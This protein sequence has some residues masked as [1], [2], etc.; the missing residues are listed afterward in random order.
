L[1]HFATAF[2]LACYRLNREH[3]KHKKELPIY[4]LVSEIEEVTMSRVFLR[5]RRKILGAVLADLGELPIFVAKRAD[6][7]SFQPPRN[8]AEMEGVAAGTPSHIAS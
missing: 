7:T 1:R 5:G 6:R 2:S 8:A 4:L 3:I